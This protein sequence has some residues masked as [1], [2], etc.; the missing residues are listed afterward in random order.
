MKKIRVLVVDDDPDIL[1]ALRMSLRKEAGEVV[2]EKNPELIRHHLHSGERFDLLL[3]DMNF[4]LSLNTGNEGLYWLSRV[5]EWDRDIAVVMITAYADI[6]L[7]INS[8]KAGA[9]DFM[10]KPWSNEQLLNTI[11]SVLDKRRNGGRSSSKVSS[12]LP[13]SLKMIGKSRV[14]TDLFRKIE[15]ISPTDANVLILGENGTGKDMIAKAIYENSQR[16]NKPFVRV[17][18]GA[19]TDSLFESELFGHKKGAF[20]DAKYDRIGIIESANGGTLFLDEIASIELYQQ[21][22]LLTVLQNREVTRVGDNKPVALD[23]RVISAT[24]VPMSALADE[25]KFR[26]DLIYRINTIELHVPPLRERG[27]DIELLAGY[28]LKIYAEK[29]SKGLLTLGSDAV[30]KLNEHSY[31]GNVR[32]LQYCI[33]RA[34]IMSESSLL[35]AEDILFSPIELPVAT[36]KLKSISSDQVDMPATNLADIEESAIISALKK[37]EG[38]VSRAAKEL[39]I[40]R[41]SLYRRMQKYDL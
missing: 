27:E 34:V 37:Y 13:N 9:D 14:M 16:R 31:P 32:E 15:K 26:K 11:S 22:K 30:K 40:T 28:F 7:A 33:E 39:G 5:R 18:M 41:A 17:D 25:S 20:T 6:D 2:T 29:Y 10:V 8:L 1:T 24:N 36:E 3:L 35:T 4:N 21:A 19:L 12:E 38:N 23:I